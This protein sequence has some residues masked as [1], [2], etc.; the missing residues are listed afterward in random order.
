MRPSAYFDGPV[1]KLNWKVVGLLVPYLFEFKGRIFLAMLCLVIAK[2]A[3]V[4]LPFILK[5]LVDS[6]DG[7]RTAAIVAVPIALVLAYGGVRFLNVVIGEIRDTLFGRVTE[8]AIRR[9][10]LSVFEHL[11]RL[12]LDFHL[13]RRTGGLS[14]DIERGTS[15]VSF[16]M[17]FMVFN[18]VP[19]LLEIALVV[20]IFLYNYGV[21]FALITLVAVVAYIGYSIVA[22]E[23]RTG[24][25]RDAA[26]A[27][28]LSNT[29]A[30]DSLLNYETV[31]YFNN[32]QYESNRYDSA[33][34]QWEV[35]K[36]KNRLSLFALNAGQAL[37]IAV[38]MTAMMWLAASEV[39]AGNMSLG[40][41]VLINA[42]MMQLFIPLNFLGFVYR[43]IRG[44][45]ANIERMFDL[46]DKV[47]SINDKANATDISPT[48]G[49]L[50]FHDVNFNYDNRPILKGVSFTVPAGQKVAVVGESGAGKSTLIKLLFRFYDVNSGAI[51]IDGTDVRGLSQQALR[52][53]IAIVPQDTVLFNDS[54]FQNIQYGRPD[55]TEAEV[56]SAV[57]LANLTEFI[58]SLPQR[59]DTKVGERGLKLSGGEKQRVSIARAILKAAPIL[60]FDE[61]TSSLDSKSEQAILTAIKDAAKGHTSL[62]VA[63]RLS[64]II[65]ADKIVVLKDGMVAEQGTHNTLLALNGVYAKLWK[66]Q[67]EQALSL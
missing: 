13:D 67:N 25:V 64:T 32:E 31:K 51:S 10:G 66:I 30:I 63:H 45:L 8:R 54:I 33:L 14:R 46:L 4:G 41:F 43:E 55:A 18:I 37:I 47:P 28:S 36:R 56:K 39:T 5:D 49:A 40:D 50:S 20:G 19:T 1:G 61:A 15:G 17:R 27:D 22:T 59:W 29:R 65:D 57:A 62:V 34:E 6:L 12:D 60:V 48:I 58:E 53:S 52:Q 26:R 2:L 35:A 24:Y 42:F 9:L 3:S 38:A 16:L 11:H 23:W 21:G 7:Q 44:A